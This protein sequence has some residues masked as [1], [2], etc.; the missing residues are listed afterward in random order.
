MQAQAWR[1]PLACQLLITATHIEHSLLDAPNRPKQG[2][3]VGRPLYS[4]FT[5]CLHNPVQV[6]QTRLQTCAASVRAK[7]R[8][9]DALPVNKLRTTYTALLKPP[10]EIVFG[11]RARGQNEQNDN[12][13]QQFIKVV[14]ISVMKKARSTPASARAA[15]SHKAAGV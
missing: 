4:K 6:Q 13:Q 10:H 8:T 14:P 3:P 1:A 7:G 2:P 9:R 11:K 12:N 15:R 5:L